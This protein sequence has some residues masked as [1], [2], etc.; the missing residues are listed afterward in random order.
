ML[1]RVLESWSDVLHTSDG[2]GK[3]GAAAEQRE[4]LDVLKGASSFGDGSCCT[5][6][7]KKGRVC[8]LRVLDGSDGVGDA[9]TGGND[10]DTDGAR[11]SAR[12]IGGEYRIGFVSCIND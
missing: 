12:C 10:G 11:E 6:D 1:Q 8:H 2:K 7:D 9:W 4:L 3:L 5:A